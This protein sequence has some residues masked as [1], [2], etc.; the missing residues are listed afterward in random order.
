[1]P[2]A[3]VKTGSW[4]QLPLLCSQAPDGVRHSV[5]SSPGSGPARWL[6]PKMTCSASMPRR[7]TTSPSASSA[8]RR[9][10]SPERSELHG[11]DA[12]QV[13][14]ADAEREDRGQQPRAHRLVAVA[15]EQLIGLARAP[16][17]GA[18]PLLGGAL[19]GARDPGVQRGE[20][21]LVVL[22]GRRIRARRRPSGSSRRRRAAR[23]SARCR[24]DQGNG[25]A[26][27]RR[28]AQPE[29]RVGDLD[30]DVVVGAAAQPAR[31][32]ARERRRGPRA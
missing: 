25:H 29:A 5:T 30:A 28:R 2:A 6:W 8:L 16:G 3:W 32:L 10:A 18:Q 11:A 14:P 7:P 15:L 21:A 12:E 9:S 24:A 26:S 31:D 19:G 22:G 17:A 1:M 20:H 4:T 13:Q 27:R 23:R